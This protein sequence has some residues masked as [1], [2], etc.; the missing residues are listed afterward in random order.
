MSD[1]SR[2]FHKPVR[3]PAELFDRLFAADDP[4]EVSRVAHSTAQAL[5][6]RVRAEPDARVIERLV[7]FTDR[8]GIDDIAELW[9]RSPAKTLPGAL[10]RLYLLQLMIHHDPGTAALL[11]Q[12]G[13]VELRSPDD[14]VAGAPTPAGPD[15]LVALIDAIMRGVFDGDFAVALDRAASFCRVQ[16]SGATHLADDYERTEPDRASDLTTRALRL[17][18]YAS[19]L[20]A[21]AALWR[22]DALA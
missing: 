1:G 18:D 3:R 4:A 5:L 20:A 22:R 16:A 13:R 7:A 14:L 19:D 8:H 15:E 10:W 21:C 6:S 2:D 9:S 11:Y 17:T 12:R